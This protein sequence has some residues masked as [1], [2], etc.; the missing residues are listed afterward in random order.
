MDTKYR[1]VSMRTVGGKWHEFYFEFGK[2]LFTF[3]KLK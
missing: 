1:N 2:L 3:E